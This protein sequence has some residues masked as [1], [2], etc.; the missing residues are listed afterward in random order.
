MAYEF[1]Q[2]YIKVERDHIPQLKTVLF[3]KILISF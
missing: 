1:V 3:Y 2:P